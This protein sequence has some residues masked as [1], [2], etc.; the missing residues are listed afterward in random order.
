MCEQSVREACVFLCLGQCAWTSCMSV[1]W[2]LEERPDVLGCGERL[3]G[4]QGPV[5]CRSPG[6]LGPGCEVRSQC[7]EMEAGSWGRQALLQLPGSRGINGGPGK[8]SSPWQPDQDVLAPSI[9]PRPSS[10]HPDAVAL[11]SGRA[12]VP[13]LCELQQIIH[14]SECQC[15]QL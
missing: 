7:G 12:K 11:K 2:E 9:P 6:G 4:S 15:S 1:C 13:R 8:A 14:F 3:S 10:T 5:W